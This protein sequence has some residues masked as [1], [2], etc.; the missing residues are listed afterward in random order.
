MKLICLSILGLFTAASNASVILSNYP[1]A[2]TP[3]T[4]SQSL[5]A[6]RI[7]VIGF[8]TG[9]VANRV[10]KLTLRVSYYDPNFRNFD[11]VVTL[12]QSSAG[13]P[14][15]VV[16]SFTTMSAVP[17]GQGDIEFTPIS[18]TILN[19]NTSYFVSV[20]T[21]APAGMN[22]MDWWISPSQPNSYS[23]SA[24]FMSSLFSQ[25][26]GATYP[27]SGRENLLQLEGE[28][29]PEPGTFVA[30]GLGATALLRRRRAR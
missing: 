28:A 9:G 14:G 2:S 12:K 7:K 20:S 26:S 8:T 30:L 27:N 25:D 23:G 24:T 11:P 18:E 17:V 29:V 16:G 10:T 5:S 21:T 19:S 13:V 1:V 22:G 15:S 3:T 6:D 4:A